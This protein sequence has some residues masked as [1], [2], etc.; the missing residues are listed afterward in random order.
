MVDGDLSRLDAAIL[1]GGWILGTLVA[2]SD[3][4]RPAQPETKEG[5]IRHLWP[6]IGGLLFVGL[7]A[8]TAIEAI[9]RLAEVLEVPQYLVAFLLASV[10][11]SLPELTVSVAAVKRGHPN[12]ALGNVLGASLIDSTLS[13]GAGPL[14]F[15]IAVTADIA[16]TG[17]FIAAGAIAFTMLLLSVRK[18][19]DRL[20]G[21]ILI[22]TF[23]LV[24]VLLLRLS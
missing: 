21:V 10:G 11:T 7:G 22:A 17:S 16:V 15:P 14:L 2:A 19:H 6:T 13:L 9:A 1:V 5:V 4:A 23:F 24:Y 3:M 12:L 18:R 8:I 20:S